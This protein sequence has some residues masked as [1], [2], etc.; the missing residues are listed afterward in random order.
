MKDHV[1]MTVPEGHSLLITA[2]LNDSEEGEKGSS[3]TSY[4]LKVQGSDW[5]QTLSGT[6]TRDN[7]R[8]PELDGVAGQQISESGKQ[9]VANS[10]EDLQDRF[11]LVGTGDIDVLVSNFQGNVAKSLTLDVIKSPPPPIILWSFA[12]F[13][14]FIGIYFEAWEKC[15]KVAGDLSGLAMYP[16][17]LC[18]GITPAASW[19]DVGFSFL[20]GAFLGWG[21][22]AGLAWLAAKYAASLEK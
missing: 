16:I 19:R 14:S 13:I 17:F 18:D 2:T 15:D 11:N 3:K 7:E 12:L 8:G 1:R 10:G 22:F 5:K 20:P 9:K 21:L 4:S 6:I